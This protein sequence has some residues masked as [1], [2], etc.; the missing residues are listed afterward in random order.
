MRKTFEIDGEIPQANYIEGFHKIDKRSV[1]CATKDLISL[2]LIFLPNSKN[3]TREIMF[4]SHAIILG[5][6]DIGV[7]RGRHTTLNSSLKMMRRSWRKKYNLQ[8]KKRAT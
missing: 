4:S 6:M 1:E 8:P 2:S 5:F 7:L 3:N